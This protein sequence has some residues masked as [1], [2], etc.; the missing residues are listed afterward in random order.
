MSFS[1]S[2]R[3][4]STT[5][6]AKELCVMIIS[7]RIKRDLFMEF[8]ITAFSVEPGSQMLQVTA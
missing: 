4:E 2:N 3:E 8:K 7:D 6:C 1:G 5:T